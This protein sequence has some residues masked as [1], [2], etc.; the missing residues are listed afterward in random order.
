MTAAAWPAGV[1]RVAILGDVG[2]Q[3][4]VFRAV[5]DDL[6]VAPAAG[7]LPPGLAVVQ[8]GDLVRAG[9]GDGLDNDACVALAAHLAAANP[10]RWI[11]L[12]GNHDIALLGGPTKSDWAAL[13]A[14]EP[15][16]VDRLCGWW[17]TGQGRLAVA[18]D[19]TEHG[20]IL[21]THAGLTRGRWLALGAPTR[22]ARAAEL[23]NADLGAP[24]GSV[25][26]G[27]CLTGAD[28]G[29]DGAGADVTWAEVNHELYQPWLTGGDLPFTQIHGHASPWNWSAGTWWPDTPPAVRRATTIDRTSRRTVTVLNADAAAGGLAVGVDWMLGNQATTEHRPLLTVH[30]RRP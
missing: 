2:G 6:G 8:V 5:L 28:A 24:V 15:A 26:R 17:A 19:T 4:T 30:I 11:Q 21:V 16:T 20:D 27:G 7:V 29:P 23:I 13:P 18:V 10:G 3:I 1:E 9:T 25:I 12:F 14:A 22:A